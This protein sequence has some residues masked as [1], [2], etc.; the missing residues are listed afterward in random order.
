MFEKL[1]RVIE[2]KKNTVCE[3]KNTL[4]RINDIITHG[5]GKS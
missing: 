3:V 5:R 1:S 4:V 2:D